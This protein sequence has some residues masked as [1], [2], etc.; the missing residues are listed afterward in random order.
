MVN[1]LK[2]IRIIPDINGN[3]IR[4]FN[5]RDY[6]VLELGGAFPFGYNNLQSG[7]IIICFELNELNEKFKDE[8]IDL[9]KSPSVIWFA[10]YDYQVYYKN[11][12]H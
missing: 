7:T 8:F 1:V 4:C 10:R 2:F 5:N 12:G 11:F 9:K 3:L 6:V